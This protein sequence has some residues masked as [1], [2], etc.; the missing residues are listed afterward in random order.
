MVAQRDS[1]SAGRTSKY[2]ESVNV[3]AGRREHRL[4]EQHKIDAS[5][6]N[7][8]LKKLLQEINKIV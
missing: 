2:Y 7:S 1:T 6:K 3:G 8:I 4:K 5:I